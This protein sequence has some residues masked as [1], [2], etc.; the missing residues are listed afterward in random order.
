MAMARPKP[1]LAPVTSAV[2]PEKSW[3]DMW[4]SLMRMRRL[5]VGGSGL[6]FLG[7]A[8]NRFG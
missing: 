5:N 3:I 4:D 1:R 2:V 8:G 7:C 6:G